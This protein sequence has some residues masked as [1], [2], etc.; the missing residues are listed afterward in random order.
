MSTRTIISAKMYGKVYSIYCHHDGYPEHIIPLLRDCYNTQ[1]KIEALIML[2]NT[3]AIYETLENAIPIRNTA[4]HTKK[5]H[6]QLP[7]NGSCMKGMFT[8]I[9]GTAKNGFMFLRGC[10]Q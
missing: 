6:Q 2:G 4:N 7:M 8:S 9:F 3:T 10:C 5:T 1:D